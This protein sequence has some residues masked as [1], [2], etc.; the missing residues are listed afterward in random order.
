M[1]VNTSQELIPAIS[2]ILQVNPLEKA[3]SSAQSVYFSL[4]IPTYNESENIITLIHLLSCLLDEKLPNN[5]EIIVVDDDSSDRTWEIALQ[6]TKDY[7][8]LR[9]MRRQEERGLST[10]V[11]RGWQA[12][13]GQIL[14]VIDGDLQ[15]PPEI[16]LKLLDVISQGADLATASRYVAGGGT[17][18]WQLHRKILSRGAQCLGIMILPNVVSRVSDPMSGYFLVRRDAISEKIMNPFGYKILLEVLGRGDIKKIAE[19]G[20]IFQERQEGVSKVTWQQYLEYLLHLVRLRK[21]L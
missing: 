8:R 16:L 2:G 17:S 1:I 4:I 3:S 19:V 7:P 13:Q 15:H 10:A 14:G 12:A 18:D 9:V 21:R 5:Y 20:Y 11:I 6:L